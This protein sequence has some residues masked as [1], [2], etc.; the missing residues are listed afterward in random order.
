ME[1]SSRYKIAIVGGGPAGLATALHIANRSPELGAQT[2]ILEAATHPRPK[3]CGGGITFHGEEQLRHLDLR[4]DVP[5]FPVHQ[6]HFRLGDQVFVTPCRHGMR[7]IQRN[8][9]DA[10]LATAV[11]ER[12]LALHNGEKLLDLHMADDGVELMTNRNRY[13]VQAVIAADGANSTVRRKLDLRSTLGVARLLRVLAPLDAEQSRAWQEGTALFNFSCIDQGVQGYMWEFPCYVNG[14]PH[15][16]YGIFDSR[17]HPQRAQQQPH[18]QLKRL[19]TAGLGAS[20][21]DLDAV[22]LEGHPV[23]WFNP[24][25]EF[26]RPRVLLVGD[27]AGVDPLFAE[28]ISYAMEYGALAADAVCDAFHQGDFAFRD[29]KERL[30]GSHLSR[31]LRRRSLVARNLYRQRHRWLWRGLWQAAAIAP[32]A[33]NRAAGAALDVLPPRT[34]QQMKRDSEQDRRW[35]NTPVSGS[36]SKSRSRSL[37]HPESSG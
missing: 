2:V 18:G 8:E 33:V 37:G 25:A 30:L 4:I 29:Y 9:F 23:R 19:F 24:R 35:N 21:V 5:A 20:N 15:M 3:V 6:L 12:G 14:A 17:T 28:G 31:S 1:L 32:A 7:V 34:Q 27:A 36:T 11:A 26:A 10:V 16:N 22:Q 13:R